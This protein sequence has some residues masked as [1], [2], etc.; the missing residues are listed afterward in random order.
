MKS[1]FNFVLIVASKNANVYE[2]TLILNKTKVNNRIH[3]SCSENYKCK[4]YISNQNIVQTGLVFVF[5]YIIFSLFI[6]C[7]GK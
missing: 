2:T 3:S 5:T 4:K 7:F 6:P 1:T